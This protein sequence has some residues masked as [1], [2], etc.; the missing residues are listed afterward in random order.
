MVGCKTYIL[1]LWQQFKTTHMKLA[2]FY[3]TDTDY[4]V[5]VFISPSLSVVTTFDTVN[6]KHEREGTYSTLAEAMKAAKQL[7]KQF[8]F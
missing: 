1:T 5:C 4:L 6:S 3:E 2:K 8:K 7:V